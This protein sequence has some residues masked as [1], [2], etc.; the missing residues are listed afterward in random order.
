G[1]SLGNADGSNAILAIAIAIARE[2][3][4]IAESGVDTILYEAITVFGIHYPLNLQ[5]IPALSGTI[6]ED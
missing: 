6:L 2:H 1:D 3:S 5:P 4:T